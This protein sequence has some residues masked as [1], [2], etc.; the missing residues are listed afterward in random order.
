MPKQRFL[1]WLLTGI[2]T[3]QACV[4]GVGLIYCTKNGGLKACPD[5]RENYETTFTA[6]TSI[7]LALLTGT[8]VKE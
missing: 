2:F 4:F 1:L 6:M 3:Y 8:S 7:T 5:F